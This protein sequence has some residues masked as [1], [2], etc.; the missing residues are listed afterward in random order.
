MKIFMRTKESSLLVGAGKSTRLDAMRKKIS[1]NGGD[2][3]FN[4][5]DNKQQMRNDLTPAAKEALMQANVDIE[6]RMSKILK[7]YPAGKTNTFFKLKYGVE[8]QKLNELSLTKVFEILVL[9][10]LRIRNFKMVQHLKMSGENIA[11]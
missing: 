3:V 2:T 4:A 9:D 6:E 1:L 5:T 8:I 11:T 10:A 7:A